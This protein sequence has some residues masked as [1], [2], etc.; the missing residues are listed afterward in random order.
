MA[1][2]RNSTREL[3]RN[4][5][6]ELTSI[7]YRLLLIKQLF[8]SED[9]NSLLNKTAKR[10]FTTLKWD[11]F[12]TITIAISRLTDP[13]QSLGKHKNASLQQLMD[14]LDPNSDQTLKNT[15]ND[16]FVL[17]KAKSSRIENWRKKWAAHR[18]LDVVQGST[19]M[20]TT[21]L[22]EIDEVFTLIG[23]FLNEF[24][25]VHQDGKFE[26][27]LYDNPNGMKELEEFDRLKIFP[28]NSYKNFIYQ[29]D[30]N[31]LIELIKK[32]KSVS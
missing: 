15:L 12:N 4:I 27:N 17:V 10:F 30:G 2:I 11:L 18:D 21:S 26:V 23:D 24:E 19:P 16:I 3:Y 29:D 8:T 1:K 6:S 9:T 7:H 25:K 13:A 20:P 31:T 5:R 28:P 32:A 22:Q 14:N